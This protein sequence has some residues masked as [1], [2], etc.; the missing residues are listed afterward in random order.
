MIESVL[1]IIFFGT[2]III[3]GIVA[4]FSE[5]IRFQ[6]FQQLTDMPDCSGLLHDRSGICC[7]RS[8][9]LRD[10]SSLVYRRSGQV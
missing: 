6:L 9:L 2:G 10:C 3:D 4:V 1:E 8:G 7:H 5:A